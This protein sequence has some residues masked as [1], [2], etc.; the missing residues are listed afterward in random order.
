MEIVSHDGEVV[1]PAAD[2][3][4]L[5]IFIEFSLRWQRRSE[6]KTWADGIELAAEFRGHGG[7]ILGG[8][9]AAIGHSAFPRIWP[10]NINAIQNSPRRKVRTPDCCNQ[11]EHSSDRD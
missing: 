9:R 5:K 1:H 6:Q 4:Q 3:L 8:L 2:F 7:E 10:V 11:S